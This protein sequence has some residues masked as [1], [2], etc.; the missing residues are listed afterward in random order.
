MRHLRTHFHPS[1]QS[2]SVQN[3]LHRK[4]TRAIVLRGE[5]IL[6][7]YTRRYDDYTLPGGGL[8]QDE[9]PIAGMIREL[10]EETGAKRISNVVPFGIYEE[11]RP[12][13]R[14]GLEVMHM[15]S[16]CYTCD[17][18][19]EL[20]ETQFES[21]EINNGMEPVWCNIFDAISHNELVMKGSEKAGL[22]IER[23]TFL[24]RLI[25]KEMLSKQ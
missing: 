8:G 20:G 1:V 25:V 6:L 22:S 13:T 16:Y 9:D 23:E 10:Q 19:G 2:K 18:S 15:V 17:I 7:L 11:F 21:H 5:D 12:W 4:A 24:L 14:D 3:T